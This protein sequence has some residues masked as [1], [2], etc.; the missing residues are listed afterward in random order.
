MTGKEQI[1]KLVEEHIQN[2]DQFLVDVKLSPGRLAV[3]IDKPSGIT[4]DECSSLSRF[5]MNQLDG[6]GFTESHE[7]EVS[8]PGMDSPLIV[9]QQYQRRI[10]LELRVF[11]KEGKEHSGVLQSADEKEFEL[12]EKLKDKKTKTETERVH[13]FAYDDVRETKL[14]VNFKTKL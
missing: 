6:E 11:D 8:S 7:I 3:F 4:L 10:G 1:K 2:T 9:P 5:L 13:K 14:V 12:S